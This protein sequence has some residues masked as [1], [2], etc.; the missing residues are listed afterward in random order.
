MDRKQGN[1]QFSKIYVQHKIWK[2]RCVCKRW[3]NALYGIKVHNDYGIFSIKVLRSFIDL[4][5]KK[6]FIIYTCM[7]N[8]N[9]PSF[10]KV[11]AKFKVF[12]SQKEAKNQMHPN[13]IPGTLSVKGHKRKDSKKY[14]D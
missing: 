12:Y 14:Y 1:L 4:V 9:S 3:S 6:G 13:F 10:T 7:P 5:I 2:T 11:M 8:M